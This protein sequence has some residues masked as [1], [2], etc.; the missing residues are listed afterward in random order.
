M[1]HVV[2]AGAALASIACL[3]AEVPLGSLDLT[4]MSCGHATPKA[5]AGISGAPLSIRGQRFARGVGTH[6]PSHFRIALDGRAA[7]FRAVCGVDDDSSHTAASVRF[8]VRGDGRLLWQSPVLRGTSA[9]ER[10]DVPLAGITNLL[11]SVSDGGDGIT[12]DHADWADAVIAYDGASPQAVSLFPPLAEAPGGP[13]NEAA[14]MDFDTAAGRFVL[15]YDGRAMLEGT[16][17]RGARV[18]SRVEGTDALTQHIVIE[19]D[20]IDATVSAGAESIAAET[21]GPAQE[22]F[23]LVRTADGRSR[24][25]RNNAIYDRG[26]DWMLE[27]PPGATRIDPGA[28]A[29]GVLRYTVRAGGPRVELVFRPRFYQRHRNLPYFQPWAYAVRKDSITGWSSWWAYMRNFGERQLD[30][31]LA[32]WKEKRLADYG[33]RFIQIDD[34]FQGDSDR[35][36]AMHPSCNGYPGGRPETWLDWRRELFPS[37][38]TGYVARCRAAGF[39]PGVWIGSGFADLQVAD[40]HPDWF[41]RGAD[42]KPSTGPWVGFAIDSTVPAAREALVRPTYRGLHGAGFTYVKIDT[43]RHRLY[44]NLHHNLDYG[45]G[46][47]VRPDEIFRDYL[48]TARAELGPDTF[49]L[50]C[51]GVLPE[52]IGLADACRIGGDGYGPATMQ[53]YNSFNGLVWRNDPDHCDVYPRFKPAEAGNVKKTAEV[54]AAPNDTM[55][56]PALASIAGCML[57]L[58]DKPQVYRDDA[59]LRGLRAAAPVL[60]SVPGQL[61]DFEPS[62]TDRL[63]ATQRTSI[64][65]GGPPSPIDADQFGAVC[66]WWLNEIDRPFEHWSVLHRLNW[67]DKPA[68]AARVE[69]ADLGLSSNLTYHVYE[70]WTGRYLGA[71]RGGFEAPAQDTMGLH[72]F[73]LRVRADHPQIVSTSRHLS[74]GGV[75]LR[76]VRWD[77][78]ARTLSGVSR[79]V[80]GARYELAV[81]GTTGEVRAASPAADV[82]RDG[83][84]VRVSWTPAATGEQAWA[85]EV[86]R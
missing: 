26:H 10:A 3:A 58:S 16:V 32:V 23:P 54:A 64:T 76:D 2:V 21:R 47:G 24:N 45:L 17:A 61:Y 78:A 6:A 4:Q 75:D 34:C 14:R 72:S 42:G 79:V 82:R 48:R 27:G 49:L 71:C 63:R 31:L 30:E 68:A 15:R 52:A 13:A 33:Y 73:A 43:L 70:F 40:A 39:E 37:G 74:Q 51:W 81:A 69:F 80:Q 60:F 20:G 5:D 25:L 46:R 56:R 7:R 84:L 85:L 83:D 55:I 18:T 11:L 8:E 66:P 50:A 12:S 41:V 65:S 57:L 22:R 38:M 86:G 77:A 1:R 53:Q 19:G 35:G 44:D 36:R 59:N 28:G 9:A 62:K 67:S 29:G